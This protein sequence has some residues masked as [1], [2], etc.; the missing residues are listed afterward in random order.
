[1]DQGVPLEI[2]IRKSTTP[3]QSPIAGL[4]RALD[5]ALAEESRPAA[6]ENLHQWRQRIS[7]DE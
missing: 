6:R 1:M 2:A 4:V 3:A 5:A 7:G